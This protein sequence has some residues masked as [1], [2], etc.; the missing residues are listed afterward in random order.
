MV[1][2]VHYYADSSDTTALLDYMGVGWASDLYPWWQYSASVEGTL[3]RDQVL[4]ARQI[5]VVS[6]AMGH[7]VL[8]RDSSDA[9]LR[10]PGRS[11]LFNRLNLERRRD[12]T[13]ALIDPNR[14]PVLFW[15][16]ALVAE[17]ELRPGSL[18]SQADSMRVVSEDY[19]RWANRVMGWIRRKGTA[20]WGLRRGETYPGL[21]IRNATV[22]TIHALPGAL[23]LLQSGIAGR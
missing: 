23:K 14:S 6:R 21:T 10:D 1:S 8:I 18:G 12:M 11:G 13:Q 15:E 16:P 3:D 22:T 2:A 5:A 4:N 9:A 7:P 20:V 17:N 19:E